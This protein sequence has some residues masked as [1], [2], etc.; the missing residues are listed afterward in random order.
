MRVTL[1][2]APIAASR[3]TNPGDGDRSRAG[4][5]SWLLPERFLRIP[6]LSSVA[7]EATDRSVAEGSVDSNGLVTLTDGCGEL[8]L[9]DESPGSSAIICDAESGVTTL[10]EPAEAASLG[11]KG[12]F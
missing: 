7:G 9:R 2:P 11:G 6:S 4:R 10:G 3:P 12:N 5:D 8:T 1:L